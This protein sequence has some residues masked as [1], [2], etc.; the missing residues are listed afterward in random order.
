M[1][2]DY[3]GDYSMWNYNPNTAYTIEHCGIDLLEPYCTASCPEDC[4]SGQWE[5]FYQEYDMNS[6]NPVD[7]KWRRNNMITLECGKSLTRMFLNK[8][9]K[10]V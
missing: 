1:D 8:K 6:F 10:I 4:V 7:A 2:R 5:L 3:A 9:I